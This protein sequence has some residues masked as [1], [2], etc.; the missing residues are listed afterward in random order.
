VYTSPVTHVR[1]YEVEFL[2]VGEAS[3]SGDAIVVSWV[4]ANGYRR[5]VIVD[6]GYQTTGEKIVQLVHDRFGRDYIDLVI[7]THPDDDHTNGLVVVLEECTVG[8]LMMHKPWEHGTSGACLYNGHF[9][10]RSLRPEV[11]TSL[12]AVRITAEEAL[13]TGVAVNEP[14]AGGTR[15]D[16]VVEILGPT[17][18]FYESLLPDFRS[19]GTTTAA[20]RAILARAGGVAAKV[21]ESLDIE[22][23]SDSG[24]TSAENNS[25]A[26][27]QLNLNGTRIMLTADAGIP[28]LDHA[29]DYLDLTGRTP[30][31]LRLVQLPHHGSKR[32]VG[33]SIL[34]RLLGPK[35]DRDDLLRP[36]VVSAAPEGAPKHP[37]RQVTN[38]FRRRGTPVY[39]T[40]GNNLRLDYNAPLAG[41][42]AATPLPLYP[43]VDE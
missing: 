36:A 22:T 33:P 34:D 24:E 12:D 35:L 1:S 37:A 17:M 26:I 14:F 20:L 23:L 6:G 5:I 28:A 43:E 29:A 27:V 38:A 9:A 42:S 16:R 25:S 21:R 40:Q 30:E 15:F 4:E 8:E 39:A 10:N 32:N 18:P 2:A 19:M 7:S 11:T 3:K 13:A 31:S 41:Y